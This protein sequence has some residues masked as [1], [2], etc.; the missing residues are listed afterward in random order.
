MYANFENDK[1][2]LPNDN[3]KLTHNQFTKSLTSFHTK[4][5]FSKNQ[6]QQNS[7]KKIL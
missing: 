3:K 2:T 6:T 1:Q 5:T 4:K 7:S